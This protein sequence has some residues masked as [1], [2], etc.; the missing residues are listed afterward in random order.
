M[1][2]HQLLGSATVLKGDKIPALSQ[3][4]MRLVGTS[5]LLGRA[6]THVQLSQSGNTFL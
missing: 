2:F 1:I 3:F 4:W 5:A 6:E